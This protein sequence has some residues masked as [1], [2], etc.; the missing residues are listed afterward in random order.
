MVKNNY[1]WV[2]INKIYQEIYDDLLDEELSMFK[3][4]HNDK[5][6]HYLEKKIVN[7]SNIDIS[8]TFES[9]SDIMSDLILKI[10][11]GAESK[12][13]QGN[14]ILMFA[15]S[16]EMYELFHMEDLTTKMLD[17]NLNELASISNIHMTPICWGCGI[18]KTTYS[19]S[20]AVP[21]PSLITKKDLA[22]IFIQN[23]YHLGIMIDTN[24][25]L[26]E[27]EFTG[28]DPFKIIGTNFKQLNVSNVIGFSLI[29]YNENNDGNKDNNMLNHKASII[30]GREMKGRVFLSLLC[31]TTN[32]K[33]W[34]INIKTI[35][36][37]IKIV[38]NKN[39]FEI[40]EKDL[41]QTDK[42][43]NPFYILKKTL[44]NNK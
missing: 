37:I 21:T 28:E 16:D 15:N 44:T 20:T 23:Y 10:T 26:F 43:I 41:E 14:T 22:D 5:I 19:S 30:L 9:T 18:F 12:N 27:I 36:N 25:D 31:P 42:D 2:G 17:V 29:P 7:N 38:S 32:K 24:G 6:K 3:I 34:N 4:E 11:T 35:E 13:L 8:E 40:A 33:F 39:L 1:C